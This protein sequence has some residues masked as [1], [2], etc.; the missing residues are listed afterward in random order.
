MSFDPQY[1]W[2]VLVRADERDFL[3]LSELAARCADPG[4]RYIEIRSD[5]WAFRF[6][7]HE[8]A[9]RFVASPHPNKTKVIS[10]R[11]PSDRDEQVE[12]HA[13][14]FAFIY[15][16]VDFPPIAWL[17]YRGTLNSCNVT[18]ANP[19]NLSWFLLDSIKRGLVSTLRREGSL[20]GFRI[21]DFENHL[22]RLKCVY[23]YPTLETAARGCYGQGKWRAE[24]LVAIAPIPD[25]FSCE[26]HDSRWIDDFDALPVET[27]KRYW[28]GE[29]TK[30]PLTEYLLSG[31]FTIL[32]TTVRQRAHDTIKRLHPN[33]LAI[34]EL[35][36]LAAEFNSDFGSIAPWLVRDGGRVVVRY[37]IRFSEAECREIIQ[38]AVQEKQR[39]A[40]FAINMDDLEPVWNNAQSAELDAKFSVPD[41]APYEHEL[42]QDKL[43]E[44]NEFIQAVLA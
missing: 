13:N 42:R 3:E 18:A 7:Q 14:D 38:R 34:L 40:N 39:N 21:R 8:A 10:I 24:N 37:V 31:R 36:R 43:N 23:A 41:F 20:E 5:G 44:L 15:I 35:S 25:Q 4:R 33:S 17:V 1:P 12:I 29:P 19:G 22:S 9:A 26:T 2:E 28:A 11:R 32:G 16:D 30:E 27:A 6:E